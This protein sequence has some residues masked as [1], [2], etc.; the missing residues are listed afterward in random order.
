MFGLVHLI[1]VYWNVFP[2]N[3]NIFQ[4]YESNYGNKYKKV[5]IK[6]PISLKLRLENDQ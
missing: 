4:S 1:D 3:I 2:M 5:S 6:G